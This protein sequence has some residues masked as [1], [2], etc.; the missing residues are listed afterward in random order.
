M[1]SIAPL[2][3]TIKMDISHI[4]RAVNERMLVDNKTDEKAEQCRN[5][6]LVVIPVGNGV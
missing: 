1:A 5:L 3:G 2:M 4:T 6:E